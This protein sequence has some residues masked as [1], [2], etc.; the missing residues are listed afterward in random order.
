M[1]DRLF[2]WI[3]ATP[4]FLRL[5]LFTRCLLAAGFIPTGTVKLLGHRFTSISTESPVGAFFEAMYQTGGYWRFLGLC[6]VI[7]GILVLFPRLA[8]LGAALFLPIMVNIFVITVTL[9][10]KGTWAVTGMMV[11][12]VLYLCIW[13]YD[14]FRSLV[15]LE[16]WRLGAIPTRT[17]DRWERA[18]FFIFG[19]A[20]IGVF[21][22]TRGLSSTQWIPICLGVGLL[23]GLF[24]LTRF[25]FVGRKRLA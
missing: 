23:A 1:L 17:L 6:Q 22:T 9:H 24:T 11:I 10:F 4:F 14:R 2:Y 7:A 25:L 21:G 18:G 12:A 8:H 20:I 15:T 5:T 16:P 19:A 3:R 13:D